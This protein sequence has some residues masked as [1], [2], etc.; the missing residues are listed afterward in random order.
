MASEAT[1]KATQASREE[2]DTISN[3]V[4]IAL[5]KREKLI[6]SWTASSARE[7]EPEKTQEE[8]DA[9]DAALFRNQPSY[10]GVG[11]PIP[12]HFL[13]SDAERNNKTLR[14]KFFPLKGLRAGKQ[15]DAEEKAAS[16]KRGLIEESSDDEDGRSSLGKAKKQKFAA[17]S[18]LEEKVQ[19]EIKVDPKSK[20]VKGNLGDPR[21]ALKTPPITPPNPTMNV[22]AKESKES[23]DSGGSNNPSEGSVEEEVSSKTTE[24]ARKEKLRLKRKMKK[25]RK[26]NKEKEQGMPMTS[27]EAASTS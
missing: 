27:A 19:K 24:E 9:E 15:R 8:L 4:A 16:A 6:K 1:S 11:A 12:S 14:A 18:K 22:I 10:L 17:S 2:L 5:A 7:K 25:L 26:Q 23:R 20:E 21:S 3:R 13:I